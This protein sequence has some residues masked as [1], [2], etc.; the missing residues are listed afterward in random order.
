MCGYL[1]MTVANKL[2]D[3]AGRVTAVHT[4]Q[5]MLNATVIEISEKATHVGLQE[6]MPVREFL[7]ALQ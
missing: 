3:I 7:E 6:G 5:E 4:L 1:N 2:G